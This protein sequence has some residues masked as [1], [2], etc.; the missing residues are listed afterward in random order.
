MPIFL[1]QFDIPLLGG[2]V[3]A[4]EQQHNRF[5]FTGK[6]HPISFTLEYPQF[7]NTLSDRFPVAGQSQHQP[8]DLDVDSRPRPFVL[9]PCQPPVERNLTARRT[10][11][12]DFGHASYCSLQAT[13]LQS[14]MA[15]G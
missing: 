7:A 12:A 11:F 10:V 14:G 13:P 3:A 15:D 8:V 2:L 9:D 1:R 4:A 5:P 6:I